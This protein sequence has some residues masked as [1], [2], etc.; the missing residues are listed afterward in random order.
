MRRLLLFAAFS[1]AAVLLVGVAL[2]PPSS[3][4]TSAAGTG[5]Q[6]AIGTITFDG[7]DV[8]I[9]IEASGSG[10]DA[11]TGVRAT[12]LW[13]PAVFSYD[14]YDAGTST[15]PG[16]FCAAGAQSSNT[17][18]HSGVSD[19]ENVGCATLGAAVT[20]TGLVMTIKLTPIGGCSDIHLLTFSAP[21]S[22][23]DGT[24]SLDSDGVEQDNTYGTI[25]VGVSADSGTEGD[26]CTPGAG[27]A[28]Y[29][30]TPTEVV[31]AT[32]TPTPIG[33]AKALRTV[34]PTF[35]PTGGATEAPTT[36]P[37]TPAPPPPTAAPGGPSGGT[38]GAGGAP[39][40]TIALPDTGTGSGASVAILG[41]GML[42]AL[43][44]SGAG[45]FASGFVLRRGPRG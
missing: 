15:L 43:A 5:P 14:T 32:W 9:P 31:A 16:A 22:D 4:T 3:R 19:G 12:V 6:L 45:L 17:G 34:T 29:T 25:D 23:A 24:A 28:T 21:D 39:G 26:T 7:T 30:P 13:D 44:V 38:Q 41:L 42:L 36:A 20:D 10:F 35:T 2:L 11:Y 37:E 27:A 33:T 40:G 1:A 18:P 8:V